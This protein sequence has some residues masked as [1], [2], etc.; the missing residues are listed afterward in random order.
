MPQTIPDTIKECEGTFYF[1]ISN[2]NLSRNILTNDATT[3]AIMSG[4]GA[5]FAGVASVLLADRKMAVDI[6]DICDCFENDSTNLEKQIICEAFGHLNK[7]G[8]CNSDIF[9]KEMDNYVKDFGIK[10]GQVFSCSLNWCALFVAFNLLKSYEKA[11]INID[12][13]K[14]TLHGYNW[15][16]RFLV[17]DLLKNKVGEQ[18]LIPRVGALFSI[19]H[20]ILIQNCFSWKN[21]NNVSLNIFLHLLY[22]LLFLLNLAKLSLMLLLTLSIKCVSDF[23]DATECKSE[24]PNSS[25]ALLY[26]ALPSV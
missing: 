21:N 3:N 2:C 15:S 24:T 8:N 6:K 23:P 20:F 11:G 7:K 18:S 22:L 16:V 4:A 1:D 25:N 26:I 19:V 14:K 9:L 5:I 12:T 10:D 13:V 17:R